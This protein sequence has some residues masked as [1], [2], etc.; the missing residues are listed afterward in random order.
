MIIVHRETRDRIKGGA[1][2]K[3]T[4]TG[5]LA[6]L[7]VFVIAICSSTISVDAAAKTSVYSYDRNMTVAIGE[8]RTI[9]LQNKKKGAQYTFKSSKKKVVSV[10]KKGII[11]GLSAG[12]AKI[13]VTQT[14]KK[15]KSKVGTVNVTVK[16]ASIYPDAKD[17]WWMSTQ[18]GWISSSSPVQIYKYE[19]VSYVNPKAKYNFYSSDKTKLKITTSGKVTYASGSGKVKV[20]IK[21]TYKKK[22]RTVGTMQ[23]TLKKPKLI[24]NA[25]T[26]IKGETFY[27]TDYMEAIGKYW[28]NWTDEADKPE[29]ISE[30]AN[31]GVDIDKTEK[32]ESIRDEDGEWYG[33]MKALSG[34]VQ[35]LHV[36]AY[37]Y[38][39]KKFTNSGYV[40]TLKLTIEEHNDATKVETDFEKYKDDYETETYEMDPLT[41]KS[42]EIYQQP[43]NYTGD[44]TITSSDETV[45]TASGIYGR[46]NSNSSDGY[47][48][49]IRLN[50]LKPG[51]ATITISANGAQ[52]TLEVTV[53][54]GYYD[55]Y[56][57]YEL[58]YV[59][60]FDGKYDSSKL[61]VESSDTSI[62]TIK[63]YDWE[64]E[65]GYVYL[66]FELTTEGKE[67]TVDLK[68]SYDGKTLYDTSI[69]VG[70]EDT[71]E[72]DDYDDSDD[73]DEE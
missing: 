1:V 56:D 8:N 35:Y 51:T 52:T 47:T 33:K 40:G 13:T 34:G 37:D 60:P 38:K 39:N 65:D 7:C 54:K 69:L 3:R 58:S 24:K 30:L 32:L 28:V 18:P 67:G 48:G 41:T 19:V 12:K 5:I 62:A 26:V 53:K 14:L 29:D 50:A 27:I 11:T 6:A 55:T 23:I 46:D 63:V 45:V 72:Y 22:T 16:K 61:K 44:Y 42:V 10:N 57:E 20:T 64:E 31:D 43:Y 70:E 71:E 73:Y 59:M 25:L 15:K 68:V 36:Y 21:E 49:R 17:S 2:F 9:S 4:G 66:E